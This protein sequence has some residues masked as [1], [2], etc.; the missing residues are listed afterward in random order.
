MPHDTPQ[1]RTPGVLAA[2]VGAPLSRVLYI[3]RNR[4]IRPIG[5][6]GCLRLYERGAVETVRQALREMGQRQEVTR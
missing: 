4:D 1:L 5:R 3:L 6:A 2:E